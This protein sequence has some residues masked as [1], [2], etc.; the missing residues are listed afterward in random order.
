MSPFATFTADMV[1]YFIG[2][3]L[4]TLP[5]YLGLSLVLKTKVY[6]TSTRIYL[7]AILTLLIVLLLAS[8]TIGLSRGIAGYLPP[9]VLWLLIDRYRSG[10]TTC[11]H[12][13]KKIKTDSIA[14]P[15]CKK[16]LSEKNKSV[17]V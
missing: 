2:G 7:T 5:I 13:Q 14:C 10:K 1:G 12:C 17:S 9:V 6:I 15:F 4:L 11:P 16:S 3:S 8:Q